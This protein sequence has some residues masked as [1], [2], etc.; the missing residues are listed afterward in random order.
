LVEQNEE[1]V[2]RAQ[3][4]IVQGRLEKDSGAVNIVGRKFKA[5]E[6][7][8]GKLVHRAHEFR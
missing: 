8:E 4:V 6:V 5:L 1:V 3:F 7:G 2:K